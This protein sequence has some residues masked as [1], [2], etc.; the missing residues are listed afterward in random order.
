MKILLDTANL[1]EIR[2]GML[3]YPIGG[4]TTNPSILK[5][6]DRPFGELVREIRDL[7]GNRELHIQVTA[8]SAAEMLKEAD[9]I[10][11]KLGGGIYIKVPADEEGLLA[12]KLMKRKGIL[13]TA[14]AVYST[15]QAY[16]AGKAGADYAAP[17]FNRMQNLGIDSGRVVRDIAQIY[18]RLE[19][20][21]CILAASF[22]NVNQVMESV[23]AGADAVTV[24]YEILKDMVGNAA[25]EKAVTDFKRDW[26]EKNEGK[27]IYEIL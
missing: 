26:R 18:A 14:T 24:S 4:V 25:I 20:K 19:S 8:D 7:I 9:S 13:V 21:P 23:L 11:E 5:K 15:A 17:Y 3:Y 2:N 22:K 12:M 27:K 1:E 16:L 10:Y 6:E